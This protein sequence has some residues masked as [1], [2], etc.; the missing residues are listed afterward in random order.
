MQLSLY[1][2][3]ELPQFCCVNTVSRFLIS[4]LLLFIQSPT[5]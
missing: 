5:V 2:N 1:E 4:Y 3:L